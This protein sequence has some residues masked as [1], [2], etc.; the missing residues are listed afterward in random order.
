MDL[1]VYEMVINPEETSDVEVSFVALVDKPAIERNFMAF[2][3]ARLNFAVNEEQRIISG[4]AMVADVPIYRKDENGEYNVF[5]SAKTI[6]DIALKF[7]K[8]DYH[9][10]LNLFHD[11]S[12]SL[13]GVT[14]FESFVS[15]KARGIQPMKGF[16]DLPD[17]SWFISAKVD[18]EQV[19]QQIKS[20]AVKGFSVEGIFSFMT[21]NKL[22]HTAANE[23]HLFERTFMADIKEMWKAFTEK[24]LGELPVAP[25]APAPNQQL[26]TDVT[27]KDGTLAQVDKM[28]VGGV[29]MIGEAPA[30]AG[31]LELADGSKIVVGE[32]GVIMEVVPMGAPE[33]PETPDFSS[34]FKAYDEKLTAY[35]S[36]F[37]EHINAYN[38]MSQEFAQTKDQLK[39]LV[40]LVGQ[41]IE[42]P[43]A[44]TVTGNKAG[45]N[46][47]KV[48]TAEQKRKELAAIFAK[49]KNK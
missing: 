16:E 39:Q 47:H 29:V 12:L 31:E 6:Q 27:L 36:K 49:L 18:N 30:P 2:K 15:D 28:E 44:E 14:I 1:P 9:K 33:M 26:G 19:W 22:N 7:F 46:T 41:L 48:D 13:D 37:T 23:Y 25:V 17:G 32:G 42:T 8:K 38:A 43:T 3:D 5:F 11:P 35:E 21:K 24:F 4:P 45:F 20:G 10:N 34:Q 40:A